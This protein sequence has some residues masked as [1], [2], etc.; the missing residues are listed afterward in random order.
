MSNIKH[1]A[2][3]CAQIAALR[4]SSA[5]VVI[6]ITMYLL[7]T[8]WRWW[9]YT[10]YLC[11]WTILNL[12][13]AE[14]DEFFYGKAVITLTRH[15]SDVTGPNLGRWTNKLQRFIIIFM[16]SAHL[17]DFCSHYWLSLLKSTTYF[18]SS[19]GPRPFNWP[20]QTITTWANSLYFRWV[21]CNSY[22]INL[23]P[24]K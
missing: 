7:P 13:W 18:F 17:I 6:V 16:A 4:I 20:T 12:N 22:M 5:N 10:I 11:N 19:H 2:P 14:L 3:N 9:C 21:D 24:W 23:C 1:Y 15:F 8:R